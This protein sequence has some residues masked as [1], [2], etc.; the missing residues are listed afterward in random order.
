MSLRIR[1]ATAD[2][3]D[4]MSV[5]LK[6]LVAA[7]KRTAPADVEFVLTHYVHNPVGV[8]CSL[9]QGEDGNILG[10]QSLI[11]AVEGNPYDTP[12]GWGIVGTH[13]SPDAVRQGVGRQLFAVT[14]RA[15]FEAGLTK[16]EAFIALSNLTAQA[17]YES[18]GF[19]TYRTTE[20]A[21]CKCW[22]ADL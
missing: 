2:D 12:I 3:A 22:V 21:V 20:T 11:R 15:A 4:A 13:V 7:G 10:F 6:K 5:M 14:R 18:I 9:A 16:I 19:R 8:R 1:P 17:F